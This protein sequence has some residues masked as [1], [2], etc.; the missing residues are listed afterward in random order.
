VLETILALDAFD[1]KTNESIPGGDGKADF[2]Q[3]SFLFLAD[4]ANMPYGNYPSVDKTRFLEDL[5]VKDAEF[6]LGNRYFSASDVA[7][8]RYDKVPVK[9]VV[10]ACNTATAYGKDDV[11][12]LI[13]AAG[14]DIKVIGVVDAGAKGAVRVFSDGKGGTIGVVPT[15]GTALS[16][17]YPRAIRSLIKQQGLKQSIN[18][19]QQGAFGL[20][21]AIDGAPEYI[22][23]NAANSR[24]RE[25]YRGPSLNHEFAK[26][27]ASLLTRYAFE[28]SGNG[29]L[30][31]GTRSRPEVLQ[32]NSVRNYIS[33]HLVSLLEKVRAAQSPMPLRTVVLACT[34]FP[35]F[36]ETFDSELK[37]LYD[38]R[39]DGRYVYRPYLAREVEYVDPSY[40]T[41]LELHATL[42][43][44]ATKDL[45]EDD[46]GRQTR[47]EFY[48]T[49]PCRQQEGVGVND[50]GWFTY[51]YKYGRSRDTI[52]SDYR[53]VP[54]RHRHLDAEAVER[55]RRQLPSVW[56]ML[57]DFRKNNEKA[58]S[59]AD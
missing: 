59:S 51:D 24:P 44:D 9:A 40:F 10:I 50:Q 3:E 35:Y 25:D 16:G 38:Y 55:L 56:K 6:L 39:E 45:T 2:S 26:I 17:A 21:G 30:Y 46:P 4:Q 28:F 36:T 29:M 20:A 42:V 31:E 8:P 54:L 1:N 12:R 48:I 15:R 32:L 11:E 47:G 22:A 14:L 34:H 19:V 27:D 52:G 33:Y 18:V 49:V 53:A 57:E 37:R 41:A 23:T 7:S 58:N 43:T 5:I 13:K